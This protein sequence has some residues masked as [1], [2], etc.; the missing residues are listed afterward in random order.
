[1]SKGRAVEV[2]C[3]EDRI[4][5]LWKCERIAFIEEDGYK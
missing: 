5:V 3:F 2:G 4:E 1:M